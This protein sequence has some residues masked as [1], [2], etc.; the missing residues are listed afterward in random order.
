MGGEFGMSARLQTVSVVHEVIRG[1]SRW[2]AI[3]K[4]P[5]QGSVQV[6]VEGLAGD[7]QCDTRHHGGPDKAL[8]A[9]AAEDADW[10]AAELV[11]AIPPGLFG[12]NLTT[13]G[14]DVTGALI[15][16]RWRIGALRTG[17]VV[18]VTMP[19]TP[20]DNLSFR[21]G[22]PRFHQRFV[23]VGRTGAYLR[24][25]RAGQLRAGSRIVV[26]YRPDHD[27]SIGAV[28]TGASPAQMQRLLDSG[29]NL[30]GPVRHAAERSVSPARS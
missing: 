23:A 24:V 9:Y 16:E 4:R 1:P 18:E 13:A 11:R 8:Y 21:M 12:E 17:C 26:E 19:R 28:T 22:I 7:T 14:L 2:T 27:V 15:G 30:A 5:V 10:W 6:G 20:C 25:L 3:D 29:V